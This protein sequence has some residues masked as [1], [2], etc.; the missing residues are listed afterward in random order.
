MSFDERDEPN[1]NE[2]EESMENEVTSFLKQLSQ[3]NDNTILA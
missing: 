1:A 3:P 2:N